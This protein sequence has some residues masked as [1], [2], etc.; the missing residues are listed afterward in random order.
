[1]TLQQLEYI[2][3]L[4]KYRHFAKA[5]ESCGVTQSTL[6][7]MIQKLES[8]LDVTL[9]DRNSHP[10]RPTEIGEGF[11]AHVHRLLYETSRLY[12]FVATSK[13]SSSGSLR[14]GIASSVSPYILPKLYKYFSIYHPNIT[15]TIEE[16]RADTITKMLEH[17]DIDIAILVSPM[18]NKEMFLEIP[19]YHE[20]FLLYVAPNDELH[21]HRKVKTNILPWNDM[22]IQQEGVGFKKYSNNQTPPLESLS[23]LE[24]TSIGTMLNIIDEN[25]GFTLIPES[26]ASLLNK[27]QRSNIR[28]FI[29]P[30]PNR[31]VSF[32]IRNNF[33]RQRILN[34]LADAI[35]DIIP[36][37]MIDDHLKQFSI[38]I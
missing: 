10:V 15:L 7:S 2:V 4:D 19:V 16:A 27:K 23:R 38:R 11:I 20:N 3:A 26:H 1:M 13:N 8:E 9:F 24:S 36:S 12:D 37:H 22:W 14:I 29:S 33:I 21:K 5:A 34:I 31:T 25:N 17:N 32:V 30:I 28:Q 18:D 35:K 6:S